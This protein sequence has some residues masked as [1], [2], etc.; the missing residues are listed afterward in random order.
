LKIKWLNN[1][2][3]EIEKDIDLFPVEF[4]KDQIDDVEIGPIFKNSD[5][6]EVVDIQF[7]NNSVGYSVPKKYFEKVN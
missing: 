3:I 7:Q 5:G 4:K 6:K 1:Y 2:T